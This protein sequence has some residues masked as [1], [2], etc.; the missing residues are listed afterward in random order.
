MLQRT[1]VNHP[2][3]KAIGVCVMTGQA[4]C[5]ECSTRYEGVNYSKQ[6]LAQLKAQRQNEVASNLSGWRIVG[7]LISPLLLA[8]MFGFFWYSFAI[9]I[10]LQQWGMQ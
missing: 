8:A 6:G 5:N 10:D 9:L 7:W 2:D 1:C 4:I 3:R